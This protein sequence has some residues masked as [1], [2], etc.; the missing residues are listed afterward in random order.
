MQLSWIRQMVSSSYPS[1]LLLAPS[2]D[3]LSS[4]QP[5]QFLPSL[6]ADLAR[7]ARE[8]RRSQSKALLIKTMQI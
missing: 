3:A 7:V 1:Y 5:Y 8:I 4:T 2:K 6:N